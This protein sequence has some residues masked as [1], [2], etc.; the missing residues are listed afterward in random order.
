VARVFIGIGSNIEPE[1]NILRAVEMLGRERRIV[2]VSTFYHTEPERGREQ[3]E[4]VNGIV[5]I[6]TDIP[7]EILKRDV[8]RPIEDALGRRRSEDAYASRTIDL[9]IVLY[10]DMVIERDDLRIPDPDIVRRPF[11]AIP[12]FE[13]APKLVLPGSGIR[14]QDVGARFRCHTMQALTEFTQLLKRSIE[15]GP[16]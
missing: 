10:D 12:L 15:D 14:V 1:K 7:P 9:D 2:A 11:L 8:L 13:L 16:G 4:F 5:E 3:P 6:D